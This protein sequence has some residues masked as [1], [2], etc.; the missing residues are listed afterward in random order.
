[1][2][3][4][5]FVLSG[6]ITSKSGTQLSRNNKHRCPAGTEDWYEQN[7][8]QFNPPVCNKLMH[9]GQLSIMLLGTPGVM[10]TIGLWSINAIKVGMMFKDPVHFSGLWVFDMSSYDIGPLAVNALLPKKFPTNH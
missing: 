3:T 7:K 6:S 9:K 10:Q 1:M 8:K 2:F 4:S 5:A